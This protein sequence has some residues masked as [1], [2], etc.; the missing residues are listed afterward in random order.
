MSNTYASFGRMQPNT[1][2]CKRSEKE[3]NMPAEYYVNV[4]YPLQDRAISVFR[5]TP[6]YLSGGTALSRGYFN[7]RLFAI[8]SVRN[9]SRSNSST[10]FQPTWAS[11]SSIRFLDA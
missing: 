1:F 10:T 7:H 11:L 5:N 8:L 6:F 4:L 3:W 2:V 9:V